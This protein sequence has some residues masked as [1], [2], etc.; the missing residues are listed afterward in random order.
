MKAIS[1]HQPWATCIAMKWKTIETRTH[2]RFK[3]LEGQRIAIHA[4]KKVVPI[5][6][7]FCECLPLDGTHHDILKVNNITRF[8]EICRG[9][10]VCT[11][12]VVKARWA[13]NIGFDLREKWNKQAM[14]E[15]A[16]KFLLFLDEIEPINP[17]PFRG[18]Q[19]I[20]NVPDELLMGH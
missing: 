7:F 18:R 19:G 2:A 13:P 1:L 10:I 3:S 9:K 14:C 8:V 17:I 16:G 5:T 11:A 20:F 12:R 6:S 15:A 4:A